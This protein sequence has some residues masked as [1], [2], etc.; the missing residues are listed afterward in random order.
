MIPKADKEKYNVPK[1]W[2]PIA[3]LSCLGKLLER[4]I[5][6]RIKELIIDFNLLPSTQFGAAGKCTSRA[7]QE[8]FNQ[9]YTG[10]CKRKKQETTLVGLDIEGAYDRV[11]QPAVLNT[12]S[13]MGFPE[14]IL[15]I[16]HS[17][18]SE[19]KTTLAIPG[20]ATPEFWVNIGIPQGSPLSGVLFAIFA[21]P[22]LDKL[23]ESHKEVYLKLAFVDDTYLVVTSR[24]YAQ[25]CK[26]IELLHAKTIEWADPN[27]VTFGPHK[28][29]I[30]HF[31]HPRS[32]NAP[33]KLIPNIPGLSS[34]QLVKTELRILGAYVDPKLKREKHVEEVSTAEPQMIAITY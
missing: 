33:C 3:L 11:N 19:R 20:Y 28:Y 2:R 4:L 5:G 25:N 14:W 21:S 27:G 24:S 6:N 31:Q 26:L 10:W 15:K 8:M 32:K 12:M 29:A 22:I 9:V 34:A 23:A 7:L 16:L 18:F 17:F 1:I 13:R 30:M